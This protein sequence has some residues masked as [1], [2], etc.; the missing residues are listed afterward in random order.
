MI[1]LK[2]DKSKFTVETDRLDEETLNGIICI[3]DK[4]KDR[5][6]QS[7]SIKDNGI[8]DRDKST[9]R[10]LTPHEYNNDVAIRKRL[11]NDNDNS[12]DLS[13]LKVSKNKHTAHNNFRCPSCGQS[14]VTVINDN[15]ILRDIKKGK[16]YLAKNTEL[17]DFNYEKSFKKRTENVVL[18]ADGITKAHCPHCEADELIEK[19]VDAYDNPLKY[20][21]IEKPCPICGSEM[22]L[23]IATKKFECENKECGYSF[24]ELEV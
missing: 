15:I 3:I 9:N 5:D 7:T 8:P 4:V 19:W 24:E 1:K 20:G 6:I 2:Y 10:H 13:K 17:K 16:C 23:N 21:E 14:A 12:V 18:V 22:T 11:P